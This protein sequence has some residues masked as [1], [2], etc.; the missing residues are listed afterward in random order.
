M[1][2]QQEEQEEEEDKTR[3]HAKRGR[4]PSMPRKISRF[5]LVLPHISFLNFVEKIRFIR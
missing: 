2:D 5:K 3:Q 1:I 4:R